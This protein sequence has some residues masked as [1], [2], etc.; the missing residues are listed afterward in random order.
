MLIFIQGLSIKLLVY[1]NLCL[2]Y[3]LLFQG[4]LGGWHNGAKW[5]IKLLIELVGQGT[6]MSDLNKENIKKFKIEKI[7]APILFKCLNFAN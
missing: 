6:Y 2:L 7:L 3:Y 5:W 1:Q 4:V